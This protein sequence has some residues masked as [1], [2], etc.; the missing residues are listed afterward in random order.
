M[1]ILKSPRRINKKMSA[2]NRLRGVFV[3]DTSNPIAVAKKQN[4][5]HDICI[6]SSCVEIGECQTAVLMEMN[7]VMIKVS[8]WENDLMQTR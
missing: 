2:I 7:Q 1:P 4:N 5:C 8:E 6:S 3:V